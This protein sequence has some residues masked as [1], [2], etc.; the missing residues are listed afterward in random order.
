MNRSDGMQ[1]LVNVCKVK[2]EH[3]RRERSKNVPDNPRNL[4]YDFF[5]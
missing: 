2:H 4:N 3:I 5:N 1:K